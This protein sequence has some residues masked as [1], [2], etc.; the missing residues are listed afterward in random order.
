MRIL[1]SAD[2]H[3]S[4]AVYEWLLEAVTFHRADLWIMAGDLFAADVPSGQRR[5]A[6]K[7]LTILRRSPVPVFYLMGNDDYVLLESDDEGIRLLHGK[8]LVLGEYSFVGYHFTPPFAGNVFVKEESEIAKDLAGLAPL[9]DKTTVVV[10]HSPARG[11]LDQVHGRAVGC[12]SL[13]ATL[14][15]RPFLAHIHGHIHEAFG[16]SGCHFNVASAGLR[17]AMLIDLPALESRVLQ[18]CA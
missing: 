16:R 11:T 6:A 13:A 14:E 5:Q 9:I 1:A 15:R 17:R 10:T 18:D 7:I 2:I 3:G 8:R 4:I 12:L